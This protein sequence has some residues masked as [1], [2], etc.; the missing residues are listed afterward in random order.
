MCGVGAEYISLCCKSLEGVREEGEEVSLPCLPLIRT[1][2]HI[3]T[4]VNNIKVSY[5]TNQKKM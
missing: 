5:I 4:L 1:H 2:T 3:H